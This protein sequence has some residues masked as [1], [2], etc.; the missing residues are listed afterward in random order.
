MA[1]VDE[2]PAGRRSDRGAEGRRILDP[3]RVAILKELADPAA[4]CELAASYAADASRAVAEI[5]V[6]VAANDICGVVDLTH[7]LWG[8]CVTVG[9]ARLASLLRDLEHRVADGRLAP[10]G[11][12]LN[13]IAAEADAA[14]AALGQIFVTPE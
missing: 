8:S 13:L 6:A 1:R 7:R 2:D 5:R 4:L 9:A 12:P 14:A 3:R 10:E 11:V